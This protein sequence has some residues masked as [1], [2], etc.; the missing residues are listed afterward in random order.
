MSDAALVL[1]ARGGDELAL[2]RLLDRHR[3]LIVG[4]VS[5]YFGGGLEWDDFEQEAIYGLHKA[6]RDYRGDR[7]ANFRTFA[8][9]CIRRQVITALKTATRAKHSPLNEARSFAAQVG[10]ERDDLLLGDVIEDLQPGPAELFDTRADL[11]DL[12]EALMLLSPLER[13]VVVYHA[14]GRSYEAITERIGV[15]GAKAVDNAL[16]RARRKLAR[17]DAA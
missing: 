7:D 10:G 3:D 4:A 14:E 16:Q 11:A 12:S 13:K 5:K 15:G 1:R 2:R 17:Q 8:E 9:L 6:V